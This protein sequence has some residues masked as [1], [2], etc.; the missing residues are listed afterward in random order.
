MKE[1]LDKAGVYGQE[2]IFRW[3][4]ELTS[5]QEQ[6]L[7]SDFND[8]ELDKITKYVVIYVMYGKLKNKF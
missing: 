8:L 2:H 5:E 1:A 3:R 7:L 4:E 6:K